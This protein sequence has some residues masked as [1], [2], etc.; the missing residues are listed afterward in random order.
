MKPTS[1]S[2][3]HASPPTSFH[4]LEFSVAFLQL[5]L[6]SILKEM[7]TRKTQHIVHH[8]VQSLSL[9]SGAKKTEHKTKWKGTVPRFVRLCVEEEI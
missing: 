1:A 7:R 3:R 5:Q 4:V 6:L 9:I 2:P 8:H